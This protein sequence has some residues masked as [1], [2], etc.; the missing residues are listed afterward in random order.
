MSHTRRRRGYTGV[1]RQR[2]AV[3]DVDRLRAEVAA[4]EVENTRLHSELNAAKAARTMA[5]NRALDAE[6]RVQRLTVDLTSTDA[7]HAMTLD[8]LGKLK[9]ENTRLRYERDCAQQSWREEATRTAQLREAVEEVLY[10]ADVGVLTEDGKGVV[11]YLCGQCA[12]D[13][14]TGAH[15]EGCWMGTL[16][17]ALAPASDNA[18]FRQLEVGGVPL[19]TDRA[20]PKAG[21]S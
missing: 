2:A 8:A 19:G 5:G 1:E 7:Q 18:P 4:L 13:Q 20:N 12:R 11:E 16:A 3:T 15:E 10:D 9:A 17:A 6:A 21:E 14:K